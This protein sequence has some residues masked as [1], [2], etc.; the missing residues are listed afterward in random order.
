MSTK[1][2]FR[3]QSHVLKLLGDELIGHDRLAIFEL[4][5]NAYDANA[6][7]VEITLRLASSPAQISV[8]DNG[9]G[10]PLD[11]I[12]H[13]WLEIGTDA[14]RGIN[15]R[16]RTPVYN[17]MPLG[18]KGVGRLA[19]QK[20]GKKVRVTTSAKGESEYQFI[21]NWNN[22]IQSATYLGDGLQVRIKEN[23]PSKVFLEGTGTLIEIRG[24]YNEDWT[25]REIR[26]LYRLITTLGNPFENVDSFNVTLNLPGRENEIADLPNVKDMLEAA[27]WRLEF[28]LNETGEFNWKYQFKPP[29]FKSLKARSNSGEGK[30]ELVPQDDD[31]LVGEDGEKDDRIF[32]EADMLKG[33]GPVS[34][35]IY[36]F[37]RRSEILKESGSLKQIKDWLNSQ[38]GVRVYRDRVRVFNYGEP[39]DDWLGLNARRINRPTGKFGTQSVISYIELNLEKSQPLKEKTNREGFDDNEVFRRL[40]RI[41]LSIFDKLEREHASDREQIDK[42]LKGDDSVPGIKEAM[43]KL[44]SIAKKN[45]LEVEVKPLL[46]SIQQELDGFRD[47]MVSSGMA[48]MNLA[49]VFHEVVHSIDSIRRNLDSQA[50]PTAI[51]REVDHLRKL[52]DTFKPLLQRERVRKLP[53]RDLVAAAINIH[54][55][56]FKRHNVVLS[57]WTADTKKSVSFPITGPLNLLVGALSNVIDN[58]LYWV[59]FRSERDG[60]TALGAILVLSSWNEEQGGLIA[61]VDNGPGFQLPAEQVGVPFRSTRAGGMGL[62]LY[63]CKLV[64]ESLGGRMEAMDVSQL[65]DEIDI[66]DAYDGTAIVFYFKD[67]K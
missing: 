50:D 36:A 2:P 12:E 41:T 6:T 44:A 35:V 11:V 31:D 48:G 30:L 17:R 54:E 25:R 8:R 16:I 64:M 65:R 9:C 38:T 66:P 33:I 1:L 47:L 59:R 63:Y 24:L 18:E 67:E 57:N 7:N 14:K 29:R 4:V 20:L 15:N 56:R 58:A 13:G 55:D 34:G 19:V 42:A 46:K 26:D 49:L 60:T 10:M 53:V 22:L 28:T 32:L 61:V 43:D 39:G 37:H 21:I 27:V 23:T 62:G 51:R 3:V 5:K 52:L 40:R 45:D